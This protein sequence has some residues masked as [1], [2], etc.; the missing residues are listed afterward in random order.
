[1]HPE[2][3]GQLAS[4]HANEMRTSAPGRPDV[5]RATRRSP[6]RDRAGRALAGVRLLLAN[7]LSGVPARGRYRPRSAG[8]PSRLV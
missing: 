1:M 3:L 5:H 8:R 7:E 2:L 4:Q 6:L